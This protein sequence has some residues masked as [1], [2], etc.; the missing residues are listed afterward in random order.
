MIAIDKKELKEVKNKPINYSLV[1]KNQSYFR[2]S[3]M[4]GKLKNNRWYQSYSNKKF[5]RGNYSKF[6]DKKLEQNN[7]HI[8]NNL[9]QNKRPPQNIENPNHKIEY[10]RP[11]DWTIDFGD[12]V[13]LDEYFQNSYRKELDSAIQSFKKSIMYLIFVIIA[14]FYIVSRISE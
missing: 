7:N 13:V 8:D 5:Q 2:Y 14:V 10:I 6:F 11:E 4:T 1:K 3:V 12:Y 9:N